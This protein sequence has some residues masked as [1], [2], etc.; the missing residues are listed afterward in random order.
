MSFPQP[1]ITI[2]HAGPADFP[3]LAAILPLAN[4]NNPI[5]R[6]MF[7]P[8]SNPPYHKHH[9]SYQWALAQCR[10]SQQNQEG[11]QNPKTYVFKALAGPG[12]GQWED[13][14][15]AFA[16]LRVYQDHR[17]EEEDQN[18]KGVSSIEITKNP[19][20]EEE[21]EAE[22]QSSDSTVDMSE[23]LN[24]EF[25]SAYLARLKG[26]YDQHMGGRNHASKTKSISN[27]E[28]R[29][30]FVNPFRNM[31]ELTR[32]ASPLKDWSTLMVLPAWQRRGVGSAMIRWA[33]ENL[34][35]DS[36]PVWLNAQLDGYPLYQKFGWKDVE[37]IDIDLS[38]WAGP[39]RG[40]GQHRTV[41]MIREPG[42]LPVSIE[43]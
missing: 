11:S 25:C 8:D 4:A 7:R 29:L 24:Q 14:A 15:V 12:Q 31:Q 13:E 22:Q 23:M 18:E 21:E 20:N 36:M 19:G 10:A 5:E 3:T 17:A 26:P 27:L 38:D 2:G 32:I 28:Q 41:C 16:I 37:T 30:S 1:P 43:P 9:P 42:R 35:L 39:S 33:F 34:R 6:F 40:Y